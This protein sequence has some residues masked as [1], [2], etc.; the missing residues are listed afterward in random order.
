M[1][2]EDMPELPEVET[3]VRDLRPLV[4]DRTIEAVRVGKRKLREPWRPAW[5]R[6][7]VSQRI[8]SLNR[9]GKW[10]LADLNGGAVLLL[11]L[12]MTGQLTVHNLSDRMTDH[13]HLR[14][15]FNDG[16]ELRF[17]D[18]RRFG[19][20]TF[21]DN[22]E[23]LA[24]YLD[25]RLGPEPFD[26]DAVYFR[27]RLKATNRPLKAV[28]LDQTVLAGV[29]NIYAD[30]SCFRAGLHP[31]RRADSLSAA[32]GDALRLAIEAVLA[33]AVNGRGSS[34]RDY[35]SGSGLKGSFQDEF[36]V[37]GRT[38]EACVNCSSIICVERIGG[39]SS[40]FCPRCQKMK[41]QGAKGKG[42]A[43]S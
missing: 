3:V 18:V 16:R 33:L 7:L 38:G 5:S 27:D 39:R 12:G 32:E 31:G 8:E 36:A 6:R 30:E 41:G 9:R 14:F 4:V 2:N 42:P 28:L 24:A 35:I 10:M 21:F 40:H 19:S 15:Q 34:I 11:H 1:Y 29:G 43:R 20:A 13:V 25:E 37:Y 22:R 26:I 17:R 23:T